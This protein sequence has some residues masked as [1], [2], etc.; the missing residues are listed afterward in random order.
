MEVKDRGQFS[1]W[2]IMGSLILITS[3]LMITPNLTPTDYE[4]AYQSMQEME[5]TKETVY[6][7]L[8]AL[9]LTTTDY[10]FENKKLSFKIRN[11]D[12][13]QTAFVRFM[14]KVE[15]Y[16]LDNHLLGY[17]VVDAS[18]KL[19]LGPEEE[20]EVENV[21]FSDLDLED[22][23]EYWIGINMEYYPKTGHQMLEKEVALLVYKED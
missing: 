9:Q 4:K 15:V 3:Y 23:E 16:D 14:I 2:S 7:S 10:R 13:I 1:L 20:M 6:Q 17:K 18:D 21:D 12:P 19:P 5:I 11:L 22:G 8:G